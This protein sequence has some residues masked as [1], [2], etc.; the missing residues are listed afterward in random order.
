[1]QQESLTG[2]HAVADKII[3]SKA[4]KFVRR[5]WWARAED[6]VQEAWVAVLETKNL[7]E[8][9][10]VSFQR[11][12]HCVTSRR[13]SRRLWQFGAPVSSSK[14]DKQLRGLRHADF[15]DAVIRLPEVFTSPVMADEHVMREDAEEEIYVLRSELRRRLCKLRSASSKHITPVTNAAVYVL[16]E[17]KPA[18]VAAT[19]FGVELKEVYAEVGRVKK[20]AAQ[21]NRVKEI[22]TA[23][24]ERRSELE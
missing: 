20:V 19:N 13:M 8:L 24:Q 10:D 11:M 9:N 14:P 16:V 21:D 4:E 6:L 3:R 7:D 22:L 23:L 15:E 2:R 1:M 5:S 17:G 18:L 12:V